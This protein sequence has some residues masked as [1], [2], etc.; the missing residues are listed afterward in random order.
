[1]HPI[2]AGELSKLNAL[3]IRSDSSTGRVHSQ[4]CG[5]FCKSLIPLMTSFY[6][7]GLQ[8][9]MRRALSH[10]VSSSSEAFAKKAFKL[11]SSQIQLGF[12]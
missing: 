9:G 3:A 1:V 7:A 10:R 6:K 8:F 2:C 5:R 4:A 12:R 11:A